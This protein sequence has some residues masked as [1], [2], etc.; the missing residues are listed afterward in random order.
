MSK[1][2]HSTMVKLHMRDL[3]KHVIFLFII[4]MPWAGGRLRNRLERKIWLLVTD[5]KQSVYIFGCKDS[6]VQIQG[7]LTI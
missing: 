3:F 5:S 1:H 2:D 6:V 4:F 7:N